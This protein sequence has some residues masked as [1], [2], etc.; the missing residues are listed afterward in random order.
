MGHLLVNSHIAETKTGRD[1][2]FS[3]IDLKF[4]VFGLNLGVGR[5]TRY[6]HFPL[7]YEGVADQNLRHIGQ[8]D[9]Q[10]VPFLILDAN[11]SL[12]AL[13]CK[14][15]KTL[16]HIPLIDIPARAFVRLTFSKNAASRDHRR[17]RYTRA[18]FLFG[19]IYTL[20]SIAALHLSY[21]AG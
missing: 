15:K 12:L 5:V 3:K 8:F 18:R 19:Y 9:L 14:K 21:I 17:S 10:G 6:G 11:A 16:V 2:I 4:S 1:L 13:C 20:G 7:Q